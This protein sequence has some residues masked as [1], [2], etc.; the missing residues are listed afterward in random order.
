MV[1]FF[2]MVSLCF[3]FR[4]DRSWGTQKSGV[5]IRPTKK[6]TARHPLGI[7][8]TIQRIDSS[9]V[10]QFVQ[11]SLAIAQVF[12]WNAVSESSLLSSYSL[13]QGCNFKFICSVHIIV[14]I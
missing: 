11:S 4:L 1:F 13:Q 14:A 10:P 7:S 12:C 3:S 9:G 6:T 8:T 2:S 5:E